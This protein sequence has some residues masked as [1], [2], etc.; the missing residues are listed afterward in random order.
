M[1]II[2]KILNAKAETDR[3]FRETSELMNWDKEYETPIEGKKSIIRRILDAKAETDRQFRE[4]SKKMN[5]HKEYD[6]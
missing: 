1:S 2:R 4:T 5:W 6:L 3:Q